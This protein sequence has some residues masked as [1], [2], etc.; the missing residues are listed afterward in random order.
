MFVA[1]VPPVEALE[2]LE[3]FLAPR[4]DASFRSDVALRWTTPEQW[5]LTLAFLADVP[6]RSLDDLVERLGRAG[7]RRTPF[8]LGLAGGGAFPGAAGAKV[9]YVGVD[10][11]PGAREELARLATGARAAANRAGAPADGGRFRP[12]LTLARARRPFEATRWLRVLDAYDGPSFEVDEV[13]LVRSH[14]GEGP[15][16]RPRYE[17]V[18]TFAIG[19]V[20][21]RSQSQGPPVGGGAPGGRGVG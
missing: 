3:E 12:H 5:H 20:G 7:A 8:T 6:E 18:D 1:V 9:L 11:E 13:A 21:V 14:L 19:R 16:G 2:D 17:V 4:R 15:R 10:G